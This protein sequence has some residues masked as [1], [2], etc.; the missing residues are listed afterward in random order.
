MIYSLL[1]KMITGKVL[2]IAGAVCLVLIASASVLAYRE[3]VVSDKQ[4]SDLVISDM[5]LK[6]ADELIAAT[7]D[8]LKKDEALRLLKQGADRVLQNERDL[9]RKRAAA[10]AI[11][12]DRMRDQ[13]NSF[14]SGAPAG[15]D[16]VA[17][18]RER[19]AALGDVLG[20]ALQASRLCTVEAE[21]L[22]GDARAL[23]HAWPV[24]SE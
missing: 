14:A 18:C 11:T 15:D 24:I 2:L 16:T 21:D 9:N 1:G 13:L 17:A 20:Q 19:A 6:A 5:K 22:A 7:Q 8:V 3:G 12:A 10:D 23:L 4:R